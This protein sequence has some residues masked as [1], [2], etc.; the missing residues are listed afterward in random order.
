MDKR[1]EAGLLLLFYLVLAWSLSSLC[2]EG[3]A[4]W[5]GRIPLRVFLFTKALIFLYLQSQA[6]NQWLHLPGKILGWHLRRQT[7]SSREIL[8]KKL[9]AEDQQR[10]EQGAETNGR[11]HLAVSPGDV[12]D[13][14]WK[15]II[16]FF[17]P[18]W[19]VPWPVCRVFLTST[20]AM[21]AAV[22]KECYG[23]PCVLPKNLTP[24]LYA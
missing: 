12:R 4:V 7:Q 8:L 11:S 21:L 13:K 3:L 16:G 24:M 1:V 10:A 2:I 5:Q 17:H 20:V 18:F 19:W 22:G 15:G 14:N 6:A 23:R 9:D